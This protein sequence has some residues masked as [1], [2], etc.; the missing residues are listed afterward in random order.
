MIRIKFI[1]L[2]SSNRFLWFPFLFRP[3]QLIWT[4]ISSKSLTLTEARLNSTPVTS[5][6]NNLRPPRGFALETIEK[7]SASIDN[8]CVSSNEPWRFTN[9]ALATKVA[10]L[11]KKLAVLTSIL[12]AN[13]SNLSQ[14]SYCE[15]TVVIS[16]L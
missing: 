3:T 2:C 16:N 14:P 13:Q 1:R 9:A 11:E 8:H 5:K 10:D 12:T 6:T 7:E 15:T 4:I